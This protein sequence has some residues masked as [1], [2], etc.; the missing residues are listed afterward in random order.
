[1][2][3]C[4]DKKNPLQR[5]GSSQADRLLPAMQNGYVLVDEKKFADWIV[6]AKEYAAY[7]HFYELNNEQSGDWV[8]FFENDVAAVLGTIAIQDVA[9][10]KQKIKSLFDFLKNDSH[11]VELNKASIV[12]NEMFAGILVFCA[13]LDEFYRLL[14][15]DISMKTSIE[16]QIKTFLAPALSRLLR[17]YKAAEELGY[18]QTAEF[19]NWSILGRKVKDAKEVIE[20]IGLSKLWW[21]SGPAI[22]TWN[23]FYNA[24]SKDT[25]IF[26][27][28]SLDLFF[29]NL[30]QPNINYTQAQWLQFMK[31]NHAANHNLFSSIFDQFLMA[32]SKLVNDAEKNLLQSLEN[33]NTHP[34][35]Y[36]LFLTFLRLFRYAQND[37]NSITKRHLD[38]YYKQVLQLKQRAAIPNNAHIIAE[39]AKPVSGHI[40][41]NNSLFKAGKDSEGKDLHYTLQ[42]ETTFNKALVKSLRSVYIGKAADDYPVNIINNGRMFAAPMINSDDGI[43]E[44]LT[45]A[46][47]EWHPIANKQFNEGKLV[48]LKMPHAQIGFAVASHYLFLQEGLRFIK[49]KLSTS[50]NLL[51]DNLTSKNKRYEVFVTTKKG[52][53]QPSSGLFVDH[54]AKL[55]N[56]EPCA[57]FSFSMGGGEPAISNYDAT[58]HGGTLKVNVPVVKVILVQLENL[59][60]EFEKLKNITVSKFE[61][62]VTVGSNSSYN[63]DGLKMLNVSTD[64]GKIDPSKP[65]QPFGGQPKKDASFTIGNKEL[66]TKKNVG[67][68]LNMEWADLPILNNIK[69]DS[70]VTAPKSEVPDLTARVLK[71]GNW[72]IFDD[73]DTVIPDIE[74]IPAFTTDSKFQSKFI[75]IPGS[76]TLPF[77]EPYPDFNSESINGFLQVGL[78]SDFG[79]KN[80]LADL[81]LHLINN[82]KPGVTATLFPGVEP[83]IP[84]LKSLFISYE[85]NS[86]IIDLTSNN[87]NNFQNKAANFFHLY[88]FGDTEQHA[89]LNHKSDQYLL[90]QFAHKKNGTS[91]PHEGEFYIGFKNLESNQSVNVL[92]QVLDG[93]ANPTISKPVE[94]IRWSYLSSNEWKDFTQQQFSDAT[95]QLIQSG[96][97]SFIIPEDATIENTM[98]PAGY[99]WLRAAVSEHTDAICKLISVEAQAAFVTFADN[100]NASNFLNNA[101]PAGSINKL[102]E[103]QSAIKKINQPYASFGGR[104][105]ETAEAFYVRVSERLR[106]KARAITIWDY[107]KLILEAFPQIH[108]VKC[109][110]HTLSVNADY[111][112]VMPGHVTIISV[113]DLRQRN[114]INPLKPFTSQRILQAI[115]IYLSKKISCHVK[116]HVV[117]PFF[118]E[119][120]LS[121]RLQLVKGFDDFT[122]Y[123]NKLKNEIT[124]FLSP[125]AYGAG[126]INFGG[127]LYKSV[128][129]NFI[130]ERPYVDFITDVRM[131]HF[132]AANIPLAIDADEIIA[133]TARSILVSKPASNHEILSALPSS[134][135]SANTAVECIAT[136]A[137]HQQ[138]N[139]TH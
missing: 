75:S 111:N 81:T 69:Y 40:L 3:K 8:P 105:S 104:T 11:V 39:L 2:A 48:A 107:E 73:T 92:F 101:L 15:A 47:K 71:N 34:A 18:L 80:Y 108:K 78:K 43:G 31:M 55:K 102:K 44:A 19:K 38:F 82:S 76:T 12:L 103:P 119:V 126:E 50:N 65:F 134:F 128:L 5:S 125:W 100:N 30:Y 24:I 135:Q 54:T 28:D 7:L 64:G 57:E 122:L 88:P 25:S 72:S 131:A 87:K 99:L 74:T 95:M 14:P 97:I 9:A 58:V 132:S 127:K 68:W 124:S 53:Y 70:P 106:H 36:A 6:F 4:S 77:N 109:L 137:S 117:N 1:M 79:Y 94:H 41:Q 67:L 85:A 115:Q 45:A 49:L 139:P 96:I 116:L 136:S 133:S 20:K 98:L 27:N 59:P 46:N 129:I 32:F 113:P 118:E 33:R 60:Y 51:L 121:F 61:L 56:N 42:H 138:N 130:E 21:K 35:H 89:F 110:N 37:I 93:S 17:Y 120:K 52:W 22:E 123:S 29:K 83:Y 63:T 90:P 26:G 16:N 13:A 23:E 86:D 91:I 62:D 10:Y 84:L 114:D 112:E 66:F